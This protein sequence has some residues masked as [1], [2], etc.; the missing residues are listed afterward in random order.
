[1]D[2]ID[3]TFERPPNISPN[4]QQV[5]AGQNIS[6]STSGLGGTIYYT[7]DGSD[8]RRRGGSVAPSA[9]VYSGSFPVSKTTRVKARRLRNGVW[10]ALDVETF[11][12]KKPLAGMVEISEVHYNAPYGSSLEF[13]EV[14]NTSGATIE[15]GGISVTGD[16]D[17]TFD[18]PT[19]VAPGGYVVV[20]DKP[21][22]FA[23]FYQ[24]PGQPGYLSGIQLAV[25]GYEKNL[26]NGGGFLA[27]EN[28]DGSPILDV[29]WDDERDW[30]N[31]AD[32]GG[33]S[34]ERVDFA[35]SAS[36]PFAWSS[37]C[38][39]HGTPGRARSCAD[40][41]IN[42]VNPVAGW[43]E[44]LNT[45]TA[46]LNLSGWSLRSTAGTRSL[47]GS[48]A[49]GAMVVF[50][51]PT[52]DAAGD[53][54]LVIRPDGAGLQHVD[55][56]DF[57]APLPG[58]TF[59][60]H[61]RSDGDTDFVLLE[62]PTLQA[63]NSDP[64]LPPLQITEVMANP[65]NGIEWIELQNTDTTVLPLYDVSTPSHTWSLSAAVDFT[66]P[67]L[68]DLQPCETVILT[69]T[70]PAAFLAAHP[71]P[72]GT[73]VYGPWLGRLDNAGES[74][75]L[76]QPSGGADVLVEKVAYRPTAP[77]PVVAAGHSIERAAD[78]Y[79]N[80]PANWSAAAGSKTPGVGPNTCNIPP[81][82]AS[83]ADQTINEGQFWS[84]TLSASDPDLPAQTLSYALVS[85][86][87]GLVLSGNQMQ[88]TPTEAQGPGTY[89]VTVS[90]SDGIDSDQDSFVLTVRER[91]VAPMLDLAN[92][93]IPELVPWSRTVTATDA[94]I[95]AQTLTLSLVSGPAGL[96][97]SG[98][99]LQWTPTEAQGPGSHT[100]T[101][102]VSD[103][104]ASSQDS[105]VLTV[106]ER[107][108][109]PSLS[110]ANRTV[111]ELVPWNFTL[112][113]ADP[114]IPA[115]NLQYTLVSGPAG[116]VLSGN[117]LQW[118]PTEAQGPG[119]Y[120]VRVN[121]G[122]GVTTTSAQFSITVQEIN[123]P[124]TFQNAGPLVFSIDERE[125]WFWREAATDPEGDAITYELSG[126]PADMRIDPLTG[127]M[128]WIPDE[129][130]G[131]TTATFDLVA[132]DTGGAA[133]AVEVR[134]AVAERGDAPGTCSNLVTLIDAGSVWSWSSNASGATWS[135][136]WTDH[137]SFAQGAAPLG[138]GE[139]GLG[140]VIPD[141]GVA[142]TVFVHAFSASKVAE[143][144]Q[145]VLHLR[146]D[147]GAVVYL[148]GIEV[149]RDNVAA[150]G[151]ADENTLALSSVFGGNELRYVPHVIDTAAL[152]EG[153]NLL[154]IA[155]HQVVLNSNDMVMDARLEAVR[156]VCVTPPLIDPDAFADS[157]VVTFA[158]DIGS[159]YEIQFCDELVIGQWNS[160]HTLVASAT[161]FSFTDSTAA[162]QSRRFYRVRRLP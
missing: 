39:I 57:G 110:I 105:F 137:S 82:L 53:E 52:L 150:S 157:G 113:A 36:D 72:A 26:S 18:V 35:A 126:A 16:V 130:R 84:D 161:T 152:A 91:N 71:V 107:N 151:V 20:A 87:A 143:L 123:G 124:P 121:A 104:A 146:R 76:R 86:P 159:S 2:E 24:T 38:R 103:G 85:G 49:P 37:S 65:L 48:L 7:T 112:A 160:L 83:V 45:G 95:P 114:D 10:S 75:K 116:L 6:I 77:W 50:N 94:D 96:V 5:S 99:Q 11:L 134:I 3:K 21:A 140:T 1:M 9:S 133:S 141:T 17:F 128:L 29:R 60:I 8:P 64:Y 67:L 122:D 23:E 43:V 127:W 25:G 22:A 138:Y 148:N 109:A 115:Q 31:R 155:V 33:S 149:A 153:P 162:Q 90:V 62:A 4:S 46:T 81:T 93:T 129:S 156:T 139:A 41:R 79:A 56:V 61:E 88:W 136:P 14:L 59:G 135:A 145:L 66:F 15:L 30:P 44:L 117:Q 154:A 70:N 147:D 132:R 55:D 142:R 120:T 42:E 47:A 100:V 51:A 34:L 98:N 74:I 119:T 102:S 101:V 69:S 106:T 80:D 54:I 108:V 144:E 125:R 19:S 68:V 131:G 40:L 58:L 97:L 12:V 27:F 158:T 111:P 13:F 89:T 118:T 92:Q 73:R 32:G 78:S 28:V 63:A